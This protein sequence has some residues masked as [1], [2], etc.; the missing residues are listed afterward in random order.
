MYSTHTYSNENEHVPKDNVIIS[1]FNND[2]TYNGDLQ[3]RPKTH[4][5]T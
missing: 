5:V 1:Y 2:E 4:Q 3:L